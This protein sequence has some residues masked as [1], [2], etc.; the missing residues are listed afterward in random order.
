[1]LVSRVL[2]AVL[3]I[4]GC[5]SQPHGP[6]EQQHGP[7]G[8]YIVTF[9]DGTSEK[10]QQKLIN[11]VKNAGGEIKFRYTTV[12]LGFAATLPQEHADLLKS[13]PAVDAVEVDGDV[14]ALHHGLGPVE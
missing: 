9:K 10:M 5:R 12:L 7:H 3:L 2:S 1:M 11:G 6:A 8:P 4:L 14:H 13:H